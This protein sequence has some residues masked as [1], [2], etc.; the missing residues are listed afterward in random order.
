VPGEEEDAVV[1][2]QSP[3]PSLNREKSAPILGSLPEAG[4]GKL[5]VVLPTFSRVTKLAPSAVSLEPTIVAVGKL[6]DGS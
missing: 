6:N 2:G 5:S 3:W 1:S 4:T